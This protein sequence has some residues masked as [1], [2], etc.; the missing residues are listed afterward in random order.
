[1]NRI[2]EDRGI[3]VNSRLPELRK[4]I[5]KNV[6]YYSYFSVLILLTLLCVLCICSGICVMKG[7]MLYTDIYYIF[8]SQLLRD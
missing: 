4:E 8:Y 5:F 2:I 3:I 7:N 1:M 6:I